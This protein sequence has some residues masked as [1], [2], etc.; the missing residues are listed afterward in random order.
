M[1]SNGNADVI[2]ALGAHA[3]K[4]IRGVRDGPGLLGRHFEVIAA[5]GAAEKSLGRSMGGGVGVRGGGKL[6]GNSQKKK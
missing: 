3:G 5:V 1:P 6:H 2:E 4:V